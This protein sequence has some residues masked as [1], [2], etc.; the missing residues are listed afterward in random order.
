MDLNR[1]ALFVDVADTKNFTK[2]GIRMG[3][4]QPGVSHV[5][6]SMEAELGF[7]LFTRNKH[8]VTLTPEAERILPLVRELLEVNHRL[9]QVVGTLNEQG[10]GHLTIAT[11][12]SIS[13]HWLPT[14]LSRFRKEFPSVHIELVEGNP[15][16]LYALLEKQKADLAFLSSTAVDGMEWIALYEDPMLALLPMDYDIDGMTEFPLTA[17]EG[18]PFLYPAHDVYT[19]LPDL[20]VNHGI[21]ADVRCSSRD[22]LSI[23][24]MV[25]HGLGLSIMPQL[26]ILDKEYPLQTLPLKPALTRE[27]GI[28]YYSKEQLSSTALNFIETTQKTLPE[29]LMQSK[30]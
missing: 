2:S 27:L 19:D 8:G 14:I 6:K 5:L 21:H 7:P 22:D 10:D 13:H 1:Y 9:D 30:H 12:A 18:Q 26:S 17:F 28:A 11:L 15:K 23:M 3:Y 16:E 29:L 24:N 4:T 20:L 25:S